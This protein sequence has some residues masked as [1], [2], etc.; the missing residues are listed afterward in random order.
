[1]MRIF[2]VSALCAVALSAQ[3]TCVGT[4][5]Y[6]N[7][8]FVQDAQIR[9]EDLNCMLSNMV[10]LTGAVSITGT[11]NSSHEGSTAPPA[12]NNAVTMDFKG[13]TI[14]FERQI[15]SGDYPY[16]GVRSYLFNRNPKMPPSSV[17]FAFGGYVESAAKSTGSLVAIQGNATSLGMGGWGNEDISLSGSVM[18]Y[19]RNS[20]WSLNL[21]TADLSGYEATYTIGTESDLLIAG[22][23]SPQSLYD[24]HLAN[25]IFL[26]LGAK[27]TPTDK[28]APDKF[29]P[30]ND[31]VAAA[32]T[33]GGPIRVYKVTKAGTT[34]ATPP[35][36]PGTYG[37]TVDD[38][39]VTWTAGPVHA[40]VVG[41]GILFAQSPGATYNTGIGVNA[42]FNNAVIDLSHAVLSD[43][44]RGAAI[45]IATGMAFDFTG[46]GTQAG[47]NRHLLS[48]ASTAGIGLN[49][50]VNG[51][52]EFNLRDDGRARFQGA[53][54]IGDSAQ[55]DLASAAGGYDQTGL[56]I[57][58]NLNGD[59]DINLI[60]GAHGLTLYA[61]DRLSMISP[62]S[63]YF[64]VDSAGDVTEA[65]HEVSTQPIPPSVA[66]SGGA[67]TA[68]LNAQATDR[69][70]TVTEGAAAV[71]FTLTFRTA[72]ATAPDC[73]VTSPTGT[74]IGSYTPTANSLTLVH[75]AATGAKFTYH[76]IQ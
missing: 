76:C 25:R 37:Q 15:T 39:T 57:G 68:S 13:D 70:G 7:G 71:G 8:R 1:M 63:P 35:A 67:G 18:K 58:R 69:K 30:L 54:E 43:A 6:T 16:P 21:Q 26:D 73:V 50:V 23:D 24:P 72:Y 62:A 66:Q 9:A 75:A 53:L 3:A 34:G 28:Y 47:K 42:T 33:S 22:P 60:T 29:F 51:I 41:T 56:T 38:G 61:V 44:S 2:L 17:A 20:T 48:Y 46:D 36:W 11:L 74:P 65:G 19:G 4:N 12:E 52:T 10:P 5:A 49:Y 32:P 27:P 40:G 14:N 31:L 64:A 55:G 45:R 59:G